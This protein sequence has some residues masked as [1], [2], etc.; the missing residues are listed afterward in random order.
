M[1]LTQ[2]SQRAVFQ[3]I[4]QASYSEW[5]AYD[6]TPLYDRSSLTALQ[7]DIR[8]VAAAWF[9]HEDHESETR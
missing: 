7:G 2:A 4:A 3:S 5:F 9:D 6:S 1:T 8:T